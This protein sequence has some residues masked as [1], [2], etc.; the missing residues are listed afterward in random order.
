MNKN[1]FLKSSS[2]VY[3]YE[4]QLNLLLVP[5]EEKKGTSIHFPWGPK[6]EENW[7]YWFGKEEYED[8]RKKYLDKMEK[9]IPSLLDIATMNSKASVT[10]KVDLSTNRIFI[11]VVF[12]S[13]PSS[14]SENKECFE[15][16]FQKEFYTDLYQ[17]DSLLKSHAYLHKKYYSIYFYFNQMKLLKSS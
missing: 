4:A 16:L 5:E 13:N 10:F 2:S 17:E 1:N 3:I 7:K 12:L 6:G 15:T 8:K 11:T 14:S 9:K